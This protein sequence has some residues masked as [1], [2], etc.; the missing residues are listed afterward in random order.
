MRGPAGS[1]VQS[2][3][4]GR[5]RRRS[6]VKRGNRAH[7]CPAFGTR[8]RLLPFTTCRAGHPT[9]GARFWGEDTCVG[10]LRSLSPRQ[11][12]RRR[13]CC[14]PKLMPVATGWVRPDI[15]GTGSVSVL[16]FSTPTAVS[17][18]MAT[19]GIARAREPIP[20]N[21]VHHR[22]PYGAAGSLSRQRAGTHQELVDRASGLPALSDRP[23]HAYRRQRIPCR[24]N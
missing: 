12:F 2:R 8:R 5:R 6:W 23:N 22:L 10:W 15:I 7:F 11:H 4:S 13:P 1:A 21:T 19:A 3:P 16:P 17:A 24:P 18:G 14:P 20:R 9:T